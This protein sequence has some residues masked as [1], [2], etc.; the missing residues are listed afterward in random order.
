MA[1]ATKTNLFFIDFLRCIAAIAVVGIHVLGPWRE[2]FGLIDE[3][4]W[5]AAASYNS[6]LRWAVPIFFM[7]SGALLLREQTSQQTPFNCNHYIQRR[8]T[9]VVVPFLLW[10]VLYAVIGG[11]E[12]SVEASG[13]QSAQTITILSQANNQPTWYHLWFFYQFIPIYF[14]IPLLAPLLCKMTSQQI[15][16][17]IYA[18]FLLTL[19]HWLDVETILRQPLLLY[20]G[21]LVLGWYLISRDNSE[22]VSLWLWAGGAML[23]FNV[24]GTWQLSHEHGRYAIFFMGYKSFNTAVIAAMLFV[25]AQTYAE[26][27]TGKLRQGISLIARYSLGIYL[28]HPLFLI[29]IREIEAGYYAWFGSNWLAIPLLTFIVVLLS[30]LSTMVLTKIPLLKKMVP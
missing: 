7:I 4:Q 26:K 11:I 25:L 6:L 21:Y 2:L 29:P 20:S 14:V 17:L 15:K 1:S 3:N 9:K 24:L 23:V 30:L 22:D 28:I 16:L 13:W 27:I 12:V 18:W 19:M 10:S 5:M 8:I